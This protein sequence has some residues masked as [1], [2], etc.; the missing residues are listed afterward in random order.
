[1]FKQLGEIIC[2]LRGDIK[3]IQKQ[4]NETSRNENY[5]ISDNK[6]TKQD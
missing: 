2:M 6:C 4:L 5:S 3:D 1:M